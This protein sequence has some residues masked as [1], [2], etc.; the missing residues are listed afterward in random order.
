VLFVAYYASAEL[1]CCLALDWPMPARILDLYAEFR[2]LTNGKAVPCGCGL[3]G[4]LA[5]FGIGGIEVVEKESMRQLAQRGGAYT[6]AERSALL[7][8]CETDVLALDKLL[9]KMAPL[10]D[11]DRALLRGRYMAA[12]ARMERSGVPLDTAAL[13]RL[14]TNWE[15]I[16]NKLVRTINA[17]Y[18]VYVPSRQRSIDAS[19]K[20]GAAI[21]ETAEAYHLDPHNLALAVDD[22]WLAERSSVAEIGAAVKAAR[23]QTGLTPRRINR[24]ED[25]GHDSASWPRIDTTAREVA[26][27]LP[28]LGIGPGFDLES[29]YD[30]NDYAGRLWELLRNPNPE[31]KPK[32]HLDILNRAAEMVAAA[33]DWK[34]DGPMTFS[35]ARFADWLARNEIPWPW[36][37]LGALDLSEDTFR[38]MARTYPAV[39][40]LRELRHA[41][42]QLRL[43]DLTVGTDGR[44]RCLLSAFRARTG[45]NQPSNSA[46]IFGPS[47]WLRALIQP[48]P[49]GALAYVDWEQQEF[50]IA[51]ALSGDE[52]MREAYASGDPY[53]TFAKQAGAVPGSATK[54]SHKV[55]RDR[56]KVCALAV[57]YGMGERSLARKIARPEAEARRLLEL[58]RQTY[59]TFWRWSQGAVDHAMLRGWLQTVFGWRIHVGPEANPRSLAN[60]P[61]QANGAE[62]LRLACCLATEMGIAVC[63]PVHDAILVEGRDAEIEGVVAETQRVMR[64]ASEIVLDGFA[65]RTDAKIVDPGE[66]Y[67]DPRG[68]KMW[69]TVQE[70]L[71]ELAAVEVAEAF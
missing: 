63:A 69:E 57:Q 34:H 48:E 37:E 26:G 13:N 44:N 16:K 32:H 58:H 4:A 67:L 17:D 71:T 6:A 3:L 12:A 39:A 43:N 5:Y 68:V 29:G 24:W 8:Y 50:G 42:S 31:A 65:L 21:L 18:G 45:R 59:P 49:G 54:E 60:F 20:L 27:A 35:A 62:M 11:L 40:P 9:P 30:D 46:F 10:I 14:R 70:L 1:G 33:G 51:A 36:L 19:M 23:R 52:R 66:R 61:M 56:F 2:N 55:E 38:E 47:C 25:A 41:L 7:A 15:R 22:V 53:L 28:A 64:E